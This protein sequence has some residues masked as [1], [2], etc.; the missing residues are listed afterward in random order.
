MK[1][2]ILAAGLGSRLR[3]LTYKRP[4]ALMPI[5]NR[6]ILA[7]NIDYLKIQGATDIIINAH[8]HHEQVVNYVR[9]NPLSGVKIET[10]VELEILGTGGGIKNVEDFFS[11]EP[12]V[13]MNADILTNIDLKT[14]LHDHRSRG[15]FV[16][17]LLHKF[18]RYNQLLVDKNLNIIDIG[19]TASPGRLA[20][21]GIHIMNQELLSFLPAG[22]FSDI[23]DCYRKLIRDGKPINAYVCQNHYWRDA[24]SLT[25]YTEA[26]MDFARTPFLIG[27][28]CR[29]HSSVRLYDWAIIGD[30]CRIEED[31]S[32]RRSV[33]W[34][35]VEIKK[36]VHITDSVVTSGTTVARHLAKEIST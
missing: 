1:A 5:A 4:K 14:A 18:E 25:D 9:E 36:G 10:K 2:M 28:G 15:A 13:V 33:L 34:E 23:I 31:A 22:E 32:I 8:H 7:W 26:N 19:K 21:T 12:F 20:F 11:P 27:S 24:G 16:T 29:I 6:P 17:L 3:P 35:K 30:G